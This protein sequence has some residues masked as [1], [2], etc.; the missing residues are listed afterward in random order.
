MIKIRF[1]I[2][3]FG[4]LL[5]TA[6][7]LRAQEDCPTFVQDTMQTV[8][9]LCETLGRDQ[10]CYG[11]DRLEVTSSEDDLTFSVPGDVADVGAIESMR[12]ASMR[13]EDQVWGVVLM[14]VRASINPDMSENVTMAL[15]GDV[16]ITNQGAPVVELPTTTTSAV[17]VYTEPSGTV[18]VE[19]LT[20]GAAVR[21]NGR[22]EDN[23]WIRIAT[24]QSTGWVEAG[25]LQIEGDVSTLALA[26]AND[27]PYGPMQAFIL[28]TGG[29]D[30]P[31]AEAPNSGI[32]IQTPQGVG[33]IN[34]LINEVEVRLGSTAFFSTN[35]RA[36]NV[37]VLEGHGEVTA[38]GETEI[39]ETGEYTEVPLDEDGLADGAPEE[40]EVFEDETL[41]IVVE[42]VLPEEIVDEEVLPEEMI[43]DEATPESIEEE[44]TPDIVETDEPLPDIVETEEPLSYDVPP[45]EPFPDDVPADEPPPADEGSG[46]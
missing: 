22:S 17:T 42:E 10:A 14:Q 30:R 5:M 4:L 43:D 36:L 15:F 41:D 6:L 26:G 45:D 1:S 19:S 29:N 34:F 20:A 24:E 32:L 35:E 27:V 46:D 33:E 40:A 21:A 12:L 23:A 18:A 13:L 2:I 37:A 8:N 44:P 7:V 16:T 3:T 31:C 25:A 39:V 28:Q 9:Q 11:N 38:D